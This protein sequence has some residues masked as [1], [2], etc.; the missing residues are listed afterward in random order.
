[1]QDCFESKNIEA[2]QTALLKLPTDQAQYHMKRCIESGLW[3]PGGDDGD[4]SDGD[5][6][7]PIYEE[8]E[9]AQ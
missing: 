1:M 6:A 2:L 4:K 8:P 7:E 3:V 5:K 9:A